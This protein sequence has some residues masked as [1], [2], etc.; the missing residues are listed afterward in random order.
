MSFEEKAARI[1]TA[2]KNEEITAM[3][4]FEAAKVLSCF[5]HLAP[6]LYPG[7]DAVNGRDFSVCSAAR[8]GVNLGS[9]SVKR[10][11]QTVGMFPIDGKPQIPKTCIELACPIMV[12]LIRALTQLL[13]PLVIAPLAVK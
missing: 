6:N 3:Q 2:L 1:N 4:A 10:D 7:T 9:L 13:P 5:N 12:P 11:K 8:W